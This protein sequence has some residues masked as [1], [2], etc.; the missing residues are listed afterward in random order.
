VNSARLAALW[1]LDGVI[2]DTSS[3]HFQSWQAAFQPEGIVFTRDHFKFAFGMANIDIIPKVFGKKVPMEKIKSVGDYKEATFRDLIRGNIH[4]L[5][6]ARELITALHR[7]SVPLAIVSS[8]PREN[9]E[10]ILGT[11]ALKPYFRAI[12]SGDDITAGKPDPQGYLMGAAKLGA[13][14]RDCVVIED[15]VVGIKAAKAGGMKCI[16]VTT[17]HPAAALKEADLIVKSLA[18]V[19]PRVMMELIKD[20]E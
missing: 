9:I 1:D 12:V 19:T 18:E 16:A 4:A 11:L 3:Y 7:E 10:L 6:G 15:A 14:P 5:P 17:T 2:V 20:M 8:T 13:A